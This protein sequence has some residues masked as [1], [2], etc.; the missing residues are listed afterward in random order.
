M[1]ISIAK[2]VTDI[3]AIM[4]EIHMSVK[5]I[6]NEWEMQSPWCY[7]PFFISFDIIFYSNE[8][9]FSSNEIN[10]VPFFQCVI[11]LSIYSA[12]WK[13]VDKSATY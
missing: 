3:F 11:H 2:T 1:A 4:H 6:D 7:L 8:I 10:E 13:P 5:S 12:I 9:H